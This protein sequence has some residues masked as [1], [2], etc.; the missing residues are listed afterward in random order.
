MIAICWFSNYWTDLPCLKLY[1]RILYFC[2]C[3]LLHHLFHLLS[4]HVFVVTCPI[5]ETAFATLLYL[6]S[7][8]HCFICSSICSQCVY[9]LVSPSGLCKSI[10]FPM[11]SCGFIP[12]HWFLPSLFC[13]WLL[14]FFF[15]LDNFSIYLLFFSIN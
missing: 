2:F 8:F 10:C 14:V 15:F 12:L 9:S 7:R 4:C 13:P 3:L 6:P 5:L 1:F 11:A